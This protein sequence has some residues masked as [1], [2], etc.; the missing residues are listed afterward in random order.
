MKPN[1]RFTI[2]RYYLDYVLSQNKI[3]FNT[4][5]YWIDDEKPDDYNYKLNITNTEK[6]IDKFHK[7]NYHIITLDKD[8]LKWMKEAYQI[9]MISGKFSHIYDVELEKTCKKYIDN[10]PVGIWFIRTNS[11][12]L[13]EGMHGVGPYGTGSNAYKDKYETIMK[14]IQSIVTTTAGH[15]CFKY[16]HEI[17][18]IY[19]MNWIDMDPYT[20]F[21]IFVYNSNFGSTFIYR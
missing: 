3:L 11:V 4:N 17:C 2:K 19:F 18:D 6:W 13:K 16:A 10:V 20:E 1:F 14:I 15:A 12:S 21:R 9:G 5:N 7:N 8:D